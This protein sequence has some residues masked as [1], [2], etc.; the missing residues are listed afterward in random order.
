MLLGL[1]ADDVG[2]TVP[3]ADTGQ[4]C[5]G[6]HCGYYL[7]HGLMFRLYPGRDQLQY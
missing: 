7:R 1:A 5:Q 3:V 2:D 4:H 6:A